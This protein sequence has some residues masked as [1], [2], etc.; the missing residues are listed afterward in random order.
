MKRCSTC[1]LEKSE[2]SFH[3]DVRQSSGL[4]NRCKVCVSAAAKK[5]RT[6]NPEKARKAVREADARYRAKNGNTYYNNVKR[7]KKYGISQEIYDNLLKKFDGLCHCCQVKQATAIDHCHDSNKVRGLLCQECNLGIG[8]LGDN[9]K[10]VQ[11]AVRY[12]C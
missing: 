5:W 10:N 6:E 2:S 7:L 12:L 9:L 4:N 3:K 11:A 1:K 8:L